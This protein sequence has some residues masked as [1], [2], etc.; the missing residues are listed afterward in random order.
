M[1]TDW[2]FVFICVHSR[3]NGFLRK[4]RFRATCDVRTG[5][6]ARGPA[7]RSPQPAFS[8]RAHIPRSR[9]DRG[10]NPRQSM[11]RHIRRHRSPR[12]LSGAHGDAPDNV[13]QRQDCKRPEAAHRI[14]LRDRKSRS[15]SRDGARQRPVRTPGPRSG[16]RISQRKLRHRGE[17]APRRLLRHVSGYRRQTRQIDPAG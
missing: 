4:F 12:R 13:P 1:K 2:L 14:S 7:S 5:R 10:G 16:R 11:R 3:P 8:D 17:I 6:R 15:R 9:R